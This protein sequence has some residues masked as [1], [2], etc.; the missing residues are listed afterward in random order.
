MLLSVSG[1]RRAQTARLPVSVPDGA[2]HPALRQ[3][4]MARVKRACHGVRPPW[5]GST[6]SAWSSGARPPQSRPSFGASCCSVHTPHRRGWGYIET[7]ALVRCGFELRRIYAT[8]FVS[9]FRTSV[10]AGSSLTQF[11]RDSAVGDSDKQFHG[12]IL[13]RGSSFS[14][15]LR[16][17]NQTLSSARGSR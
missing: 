9:S 3:P 17:I 14:T 4:R 16:L 13:M 12:H 1:S 10:A 15:V 5:P 7:L 8:Q 6:C 2:A 11:H